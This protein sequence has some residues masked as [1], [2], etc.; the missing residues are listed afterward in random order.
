MVDH[1][2][3][4]IDWLDKLHADLETEGRNDDLYNRLGVAIAMLKGEYDPDTNGEPAL[5]GPQKIE[6]VTI[7]SPT[8]STYPLT[9]I[10]PREGAEFD[11]LALWGNDEN[12]VSLDRGQA[13]KLRDVLDRWLGHERVAL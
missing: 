4:G 9:V 11:T 12:L 8:D 6:R 10:P 7:T 3:K 13:A 2:T 5:P 1:V